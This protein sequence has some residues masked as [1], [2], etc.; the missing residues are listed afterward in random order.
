VG[1]GEAQVVV[2]RAIAD[3]QVRMGVDAQSVTVQEVVPIEFSDASLGVPEPGVVYAQVLTPGYVI[4]LAVGDQVYTYH[5]SGERVVLV[6]SEP[7][8][9]VGESQ[10]PPLSSEDAYHRVEIA[11]TGLSFEVPSGWLRLDPEWAWTPAEGSGLLLAVN[12]VD[13][14]PPAEPEAVLLPN[15]AQTLYSEEVALAWG[16]GRRFL[17]EVYAPAAQ[18]G[19]EKAPVESV[20]IHVLA[21][22]QHGEVTRAFDLY[23]RG[24]GMEDM[25][26]LDPL[27]QRVLNSS[28]M[29]GVALQTPLAGNLAAVGSDP[30]TGWS[31]LRDDAYGYQIAI[32][33]DWTWKEF[34]TEGPGMPEDWP[35]VRMA[36]LYPQAWDADINR[37]GP[38]DPNAKP[39]IAPLQLEV[40]VG[41]PEQFRRVYP[42]PM[43]TEQIEINGL[44]VT[45]EKEI[46]DAMTLIRYVFASPENPELYVTLSDQMT[47]FPDRVSGNEA[48]ADL[49]PAVV[50]TFEFAR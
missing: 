41:P 12:W 24:A 32:P 14:S 22:V 45:V 5:G 28:T 26:T 17:L 2:E 44:T 37:S 27:L 42:E 13:L 47:G 49:V 15:H 11:D 34:P 31:V 20:E 50:A 1:Y 23:V 16:Q 7:G 10:M 8:P 43:Q 40:V 38:P 46:Y 39:V 48:I 35:T 36:I 9:N 33:A 4:H 21:K 29:A 6:P 30:A 18:G 19:D 3:I 25:G